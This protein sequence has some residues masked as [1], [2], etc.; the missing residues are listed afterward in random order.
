M[1]TCDGGGVQAEYARCSDGRTRFITGWDQFAIR[2][3]L[4]PR[5]DVLMMFYMNMWPSAMKIV[6]HVL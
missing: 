2:N 1:A 4:A 6:L 3:N 5:M